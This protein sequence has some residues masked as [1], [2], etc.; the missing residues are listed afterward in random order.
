M[1]DT[2]LMGSSG[3]YLP[4]IS[5]PPFVLG[6]PTKVLTLLLLSYFP[7]IYSTYFLLL[8]VFNKM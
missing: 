2:I 8:S 1:P 6:H 3:I 4:L 5:M 7:M